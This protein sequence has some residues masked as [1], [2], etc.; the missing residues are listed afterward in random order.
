MESKT[1]FKTDFETEFETDFKTKFK[2]KKFF[3][4]VFPYE[5]QCYI[6]TIFVFC[7]YYVFRYKKTTK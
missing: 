4:A 1:N 5:T 7:I 3:V 6:I 2:S